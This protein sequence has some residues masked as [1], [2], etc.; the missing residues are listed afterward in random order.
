MWC[1]TSF[2]FF[3]HCWIHL[4]FWWKVENWIEFALFLCIFNLQSLISMGTQTVSPF[5]NHSFQLFPSSLRVSFLTTH[6][7][8]HYQFPNLTSPF[9][10]HP[11]YKCINSIVL[12]LYPSIP[13]WIPTQCCLYW[14]SPSVTTFNVLT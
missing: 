13:I 5:S 2:C 3:P 1:L 8:Y 11:N 4:L 14:L 12:I 6:L 10:D 7:Q 9:H